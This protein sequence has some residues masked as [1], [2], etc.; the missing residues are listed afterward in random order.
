MTGQAWYKQRQA[1]GVCAW[2]GCSIE[3]KDTDYCP[4]HDERTK[5]RKRDWIAKRRAKA[6]AKKLCS[7]CTKRQR[8]GR[9]AYCA[10]CLIQQA[11]RRKLH[12]TRDVDKSQ[13]VASRILAWENS[14]TNEGRKRLRGGKRGRPDIESENRL[15][16]EDF[17]KNVLI[18][19]D[20]L[21]VVDSP[22]QAALPPI[23]RQDAREAAAAWWLLAARQALVLARRNGITLPPELAVLIS[24]DPLDDGDT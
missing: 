5:Q 21:A 10:T 1:K 24:D 19:V 23:Q 8:R 16:V 22:E 9:S 12:V 11:K 15:D 18:A 4:E 6:K 14:P 20:A 13:R 17:Q 2:S 7:R 3:T